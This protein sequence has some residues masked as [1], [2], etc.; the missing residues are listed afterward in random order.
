[1]TKGE[2]NYTATMAKVYAEQDIWKKRRRFTN[3]SGEGARRTDIMNALSEI[4]KKLVGKKA[5]TKNLVSIFCRW[6]DLAEGYGNFKNKKNSGAA[7]KD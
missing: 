2:N 4:E 5:D 6:I 3:P 7:W 1:M